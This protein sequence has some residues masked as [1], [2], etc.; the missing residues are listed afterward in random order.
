VTSN[1]TIDGYLM[2]LKLT[3]T[4]TSIVL[5]R[6][7]ASPRRA[8]SR[9][10][11]GM[12]ITVPPHWCRSH[13]YVRYLTESHRGGKFQSGTE[14]VLKSS[15]PSSSLFRR[16][17]RSFHRRVSG[18]LVSTPTP[19]GLILFTHSNPCRS[20]LRALLGAFASGRGCCAVNILTF[21]SYYCIKNM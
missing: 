16:G 14:V 15:A 11:V 10:E 3:V 4:G 21:S 5:K 12:S 7:F 13:P 18:S 6:M 1:G 8:T 17:T 19:H 20:R 9:Q 2:F